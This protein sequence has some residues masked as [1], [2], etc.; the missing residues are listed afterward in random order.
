[1][2]TLADIP[3]F[4]WDGSG[5]NPYFGLLGLAD[6]VAVTA[7]SVSMVSEAA[8]TGKPVY[9]LELPGA[10][11]KFAEFHAHMRRKGITRPLGAAFERWTYPPLDD[12][13]RAAAAVRRLLERR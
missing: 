6:A 2:R 7:D 8:V 1:E 12:M 5:E 11:G 4:L 13:A 10:G 3:A 9:I